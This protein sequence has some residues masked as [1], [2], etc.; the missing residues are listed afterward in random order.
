M[1]ADFAGAVDFAGAAYFAV[2]AY[3]AGAADFA[4]VSSLAPFASAALSSLAT[5]VFVATVDGADV[6][7]ATTVSF[8]NLLRVLRIF[9]GGGSFARPTCRGTLVTLSFLRRCDC[10]RGVGGSVVRALPFFFGGIVAVVLVQVGIFGDWG[11]GGGSCGD[12]GWLSAKH[13]VQARLKWV[14]AAKR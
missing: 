12:G 10:R 6:V 14:T 8:C 7:F 9:G 5:V 11:E 4:A 13:V 1:V 3:F 2:A